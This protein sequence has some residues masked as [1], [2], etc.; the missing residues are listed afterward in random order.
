M[1]TLKVRSRFVEN[2]KKVEKVNPDLA[3]ALRKVYELAKA[4][5][6]GLILLRTQRDLKKAFPFKKEEKPEE[7]ES[8]EEEIPEEKSDEEGAETSDAEEPVDA[9]EGTKKIVM[10]VLE[11]LG[12]VERTEG[13]V[14]AVI[15]G[16]AKSITGDVAQIALAVETLAEE[17]SKVSSGPVLREL[18][19]LQGEKLQVH[20]QIDSLKKT[21]ANTKDPAARQSLQNEIARLNISLIQ[22]KE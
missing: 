18:G 4:P 13:M 2:I 10:D 22:Q 7:E 5:S 1:A 6:D 15:P 19:P 11:E 20:Q 16:F 14:K 3:Q 12:L 17:L 9:A 8:T 21:L